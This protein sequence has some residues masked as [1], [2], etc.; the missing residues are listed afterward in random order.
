MCNIIDPKFLR[1]N[2]FIK[3][4][5]QGTDY[6]SVHSHFSLCVWTNDVTNF[7]IVTQIISPLTCH[8]RFSIFALKFKKKGLA[9]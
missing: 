7:L 6:K 9:M 5:S 1:K 2:V 3:I 8:L 4:V